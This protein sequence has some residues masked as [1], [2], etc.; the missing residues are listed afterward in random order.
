MGLTP[1]AIGVEQE[2]IP[3][4]VMP[5]RRR[6]NGIVIVGEMYPKSLCE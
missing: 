1:F 5:T 4:I 3:K 2:W 6:G